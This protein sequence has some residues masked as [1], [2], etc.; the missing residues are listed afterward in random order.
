MNTT[1]YRKL[2]F[3]IGS[4]NENESQVAVHRLR[5]ALEADGSSWNEF[6]ADLSLNTVVVFEAPPSDEE[7]QRKAA[8]A[9]RKEC[10]QDVL[11]RANE[12][13]INKLRNQT[14]HRESVPK[15]AQELKDK[16][17]NKFY[18]QFR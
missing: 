14:K 1:L 2:L 6:V 18:S 12:T 7:L 4:P 8:E 16:N 15:N 5:D 3:M 9:A 17:K 11:N 10:Q 13:A